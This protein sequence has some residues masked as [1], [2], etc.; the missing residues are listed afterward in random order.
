MGG[1]PRRSHSYSDGATP[2]LS[3]STL[4]LLQIQTAFLLSS[5]KPFFCRPS[6]SMY[7]KYY[8]NPQSSPFQS[9]LLS[10]LVPFHNAK[11]TRV[12]LSVYYKV[13]RS[14]NAF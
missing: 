9:I 1:V 14:N 5:Q 6:L 11:D 8:C 2:S 7:Q 3:L 4:P 13:A 10:L 12:V